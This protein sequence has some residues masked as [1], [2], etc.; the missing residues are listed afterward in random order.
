MWETGNVTATVPVGGGAAGV[1]YDSANGDVYVTDLS[2]DL[3][4]VL[5]GAT[6]SAIGTIPV[7]T[8][9]SGVAYDSGNGDLYVTNFGSNNV[10][11]INGATN[12]VVKTIPSGAG[13]EPIAA[14]YDSGN[15]YLYVANEGKSNVSVVN[16]ATNTAIAA[17]PVGTDPVADLYDPSNG[18][19]YV[20]NGGT[21]TVSV[22]T[23]TSSTTTT[24][25]VQNGPDILAYDGADGDIYVPNFNSNSISVITPSTNMVANLNLGAGTEPDS[26][27]YDSGNGDL[28]LVLFETAT[29]LV[30]SGMTNSLLGSI[31]IGTH[32]IEDAYDDTNGDVYV[33]NSGPGTVSVI[34]TLLMVNGAGANLRGTG[35]TGIAGATIGVGSVP[36]G[37]AFDSGNSNVFVANAGSNNL[38]VI[39]SATNSVVGTVSVGTS[40]SSLAVDSA[41]GDVYVTNSGAKTVT[42]FSG[43]TRAIL[44]TLNVGSGPLG[45]AYD[46]GNG[47]VY[48][49]NF[50]SNNVSVFSGATN[51]LAATISVG[52]G[53][54]GVAYDSANGEVYVANVGSASVSVINGATNSLATTIALGVSSFAA[55]SILFDSGNGDLYVLTP[56]LASVDVIRGATNTV[57]ASVGVGSF[58]HGEAYDTANGDVYVA[59]S[60]P[61]ELS[62]ISGLTNSVVG[63]ISENAG[64]WAVSYDSAN[65]DLFAANLDSNSVTVV[66]TLTGVVIPSTAI[67][68]VGQSLLVAAPLVGEGTGRVVMTLGSSN[69]SGLACSAD[70]VGPSEISGACLAEAPGTYLVTLTVTDSAGNSV[71][72]SLTVRVDSTPVGTLPIG[73]PASIDVGQTTSL[74]TTT[75]GGSRAYTYNWSG[76]PDGCASQDTSNLTCTPT[77]AGEAKINV[78]AVDG[79]EFSTTAGPLTLPVSPDPAVGAPTATPATPEV[80]QSL[81]LTAVSGNAGSGGDFYAWS[82]LPGNCTSTDSLTLTCSPTTPG[83]FSVA[84]SVQDSNGMQVVSAPLVLEIAP[85]LGVPLVS[86]SVS[87][88]DVGQTVALGASVS[89]GSDAY[90]YFWSGLPTGCASIDA[91]AL[92]CAPAVT[93]SFPIV[94]S[95][96][97]PSGVNRTSAALML[98]VSPRLGTPTLSVSR[99]A[100]DVG[101]TFTLTASASGGSGTYGYT[102]SDLPPGCASANSP[103]VVC[104]PTS[105]PN[106]YSPFVSVED[107]NGMVLA[108]SPHS[109]V[110]S[111]ALAV[112]TLTPS[113]ATVDVGQTVSFTAGAS[114]GAGGDSYRWSGAPTGCQNPLGYQL[115]CTPS[116]AGTFAVTVQ[117]TD[118]NGGNTSSLPATL[119]VSSPL[120]ALDVSSSLSTVAVGETVIL[121]VSPEGGSGG[122]TYTWSGLPAGCASEDSATLACVPTATTGSPVTV[123]VT[124]TDSN[125]ASLTAS[126]PRLTIVAAAGPSTG[127]GTGTSSTELAALGLALLAVALALV[128]LV[129]AFPRR[130]IPPASPPPG[131][132]GV[133]AGES[134]AVAP[135]ATAPASPTPAWDEGQPTVGA[136]P[137]Q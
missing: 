116:I 121:S 122:D 62:V 114:G 89:G 112:P 135:G 61:T 95:A 94:V 125:G 15:G 13:S 43:T 84:V 71:Q 99:S 19:V 67:E 101:Q 10:S 29:V 81:T 105:S 100:V 26:I 59:D 39:N 120:L 118:A 93:G 32:P 87:S 127:T 40:P 111:S 130:G 38:S 17:I 35:E 50:D 86:A 51:T 52:M 55:T 63:T 70:P 8:D 134:A 104:T 2:S 64:P 137:G 53:P 126:L 76:L 31:T 33:T 21:N 6:N 14:A 102:W 45:V 85:P 131:A 16:G 109:V 25:T 103:T 124:V 119:L 54:Y 65:G 37:T 88:L 75:S 108:S 24:V 72:S 44:R 110:V 92:S 28:Y 11:V 57:L 79:F 133:P 78:T 98:V 80:N 60:T 56:D 97:D 47:D 73:V 3:V 107:S 18:A 4:T 58:P 41:N 66:P 106:M 123:S 74:T 83:T 9:P 117:V 7:G 82:G 115:S 30:W 34:S 20:S 96:L 90:T 48:V 5:N 69:D 113:V 128:A 91:A 136:P 132:T 22:I 36:N 1:A 77:A 42:V 46:S 12:L 27:A 23:G 129:V 49:A 68:D